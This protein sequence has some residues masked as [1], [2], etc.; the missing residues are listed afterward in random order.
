MKGWWTNK[1]IMQRAPSTKDDVK[2]WGLIL[3]SLFHAYFSIILF[4]KYMQT[5][6]LRERGCFSEI[7]IL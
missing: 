3:L 5:L 6:Y 1:Q 4:V 7:F 2:L